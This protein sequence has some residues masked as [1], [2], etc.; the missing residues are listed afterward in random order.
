[1][2]HFDGL[3]VARHG[4]LSFDQLVTRHGLLS[5]DQLVAPIVHMTGLDEQRAREFI[6]TLDLNEDGFIDKQEF[7]D[8]WALM[9][10]D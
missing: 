6:M 1:M 7:M 10:Q 8:M 9:F 4:L 3:D 5:F 2:Q